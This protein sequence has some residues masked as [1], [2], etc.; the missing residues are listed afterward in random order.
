VYRRSQGIATHVQRLAVKVD[1][2]IDFYRKHAVWPMVAWGLANNKASIGKVIVVN[3]DLWTHG[4]RNM[5]RDTLDADVPLLL[6]DHPHDGYGGHRCFNEGVAQVETE[7][8]CG[9]NGD[10]VLAPGSLATTLEC[11][12]EGL[13]IFDWTH[14]VPRDVTLADF[15]DP[16]I[17]RRD[18]RIEHPC[19]YY[20]YD[21]RFTYMVAHTASHHAIGGANCTMPDYGLVDYDYGCRWAL[22]HGRD[23]FLVG[24][25]GCAYHIGGKDRPEDKVGKSD[26][27]G[28]LPQ[29]KPY[30]IAF[31]KMMG[32]D[33]VDLDEDD[34]PC[35]K[36]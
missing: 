5:M 35:P 4:E 22:K 13:V 15:P 25:G 26:G 12:D 28:N 7:H 33:T 30:A 11:A 32:F 3:D 16:P 27:K 10:I 19:P 8:F 17:E 36:S 9:I 29:V 20:V 31:L 21:F 2:V 14:D 24:A 18:W 34:T 6:L 1:V 23:S